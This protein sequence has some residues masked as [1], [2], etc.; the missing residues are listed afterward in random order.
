MATGS[1][2]RKAGPPVRSYCVKVLESRRCERNGPEGR[3]WRQT[4]EEAKW[5]GGGAEGR[6]TPG[7]LGRMGLRGKEVSERRVAGCK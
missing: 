2:R 1:G 7:A 6:Q 5:G 3:R 4:Q